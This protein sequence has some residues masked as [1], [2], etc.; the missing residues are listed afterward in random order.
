M[1]FLESFNNLL[2]FVAHAAKGRG[3]KSEIITNCVFT[4]HRQHLVWIATVKISCA[5]FWVGA[6]AL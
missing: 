3:H 1:L 5:A 6:K 2:F 4:P